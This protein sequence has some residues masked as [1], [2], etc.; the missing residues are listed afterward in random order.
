MDLASRWPS[1]LRKYTGLITVQREKVRE[2][3]L[4]E[5]EGRAE[6]ECEW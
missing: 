1:G 3:G 5:G 2:N 6:S 4:R